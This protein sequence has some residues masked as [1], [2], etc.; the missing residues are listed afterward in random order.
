MRLIRLG[1]GAWTVLATCSA[2]GDCPTL[3]FVASLDQR[4][5]DRVLAD[6]REFVPGTS[7]SH[8][9]RT[10]FSRKLKGVEGIFEFR[11]PTSG[12]GTPRLLW[13]FDENKV[14]VCSNGADKKG[15][16]RQREIEIAQETR[17]WYLLAKQKSD[18]QVIDLANLDRNWDEEE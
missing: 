16:L 17:Q 2:N 8:W 18:L 7:P 6:L 13:F 15:R 10:E 12:G 5:G 1:K 11:W 4:R 3:D 9:A 14:I